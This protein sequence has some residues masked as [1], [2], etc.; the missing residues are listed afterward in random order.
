MSHPCKAVLI[1]PTATLLLLLVASEGYSQTTRSRAPRRYRGVANEPY[2]SPYMNLVRPDGDAAFNYSTLVQPQLQQ[3]QFN[4]Q[5]A[6]ENFAFGRQIQQT[7]AEIMTPYGLRSTM[8]PTGGVATR[9]NYSHYYPDMGGGPS[10]GGRKFTSS[11][12]GGGGGMLGGGMG[13]TGG[14]GGFGGGF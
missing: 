12:G 10:G 5:Q 11:L 4:Q 13:G 1:V 2:I 6:Q 14:M 8:R 3:M 7:Q 9:M